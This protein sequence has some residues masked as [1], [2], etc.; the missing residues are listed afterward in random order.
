MRKLAPQEVRT[1]FVTSVTWG[2][3]SLFQTDRMAGLFIKVLSSA[4]EQVLLHEW[5]LM[6][7][8]FHLLITPK[9]D[10]SLERA[11]QR[12]K[13]GFSFRA[14]K[15]LGFSGEIWQPGFTEH[16]IQD[17]ADYDVHRRYILENP[18]RARLSDS[19]PYVST[20]GVIELDEPPPGLKPNP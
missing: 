5:V 13:G 3:R 16:R 17:A 6:P 15:E 18:G 9:P 12:I 11:L 1:F 7:N 8:H 2:R 4:R 20:S 19:Y 10:I 14:K